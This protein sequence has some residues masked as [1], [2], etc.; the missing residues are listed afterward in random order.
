MCF[1]V[2]G[3][4]QWD[5]NVKLGVQ[6]HWR[7]SLVVARNQRNWPQRKALSSSGG[8]GGD[9]SAAPPFTSECCAASGSIILDDNS[10]SGWLKRSAISLRTLATVIGRSAAFALN[11]GCRHSVPL[12]KGRPF[13]QLAGSPSVP[14]VLWPVISCGYLT[15]L[16]NSRA[17]H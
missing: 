4:Y 11:A 2:A 6:T 3:V 13:A 8:P 7:C 12:G 1:L 15:V 5:Q 9:E 14:S 17:P 10:P 16:Q